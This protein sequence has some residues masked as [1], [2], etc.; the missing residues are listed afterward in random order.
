MQLLKHFKELTVHP[1]NA[2]ELKGLIL[3]LAIQGK[4]T[5][6]W[7][8][9]NP[10]VE[11]ASV[12]LEKILE[13]K[14]QLINDKKI[15]KEKV[16]DDVLPDQ[17][18]DLPNG[19]IKTRL[20]EVIQI[21]RGITFPSSE[22][23]KEDYEG[24][25]PCLRTANV[26]D[27]IDWDDLLYID[28]KYVKRE[29]QILQAGDVIM[30]MAN[31]RE[32]VGKV[33]LLK[34]EMSREFTLG[35]FISALRTYV[36]DPE[37]LMVLLRNP[38]TKNELIASSSQTTNIANV[39]IAKLRPLIIS[40]PPLEEQ[41]AIV[42]TVNQ[43]F[44][45]VEALEKQTQ[46]RV[47]LKEDFVTSALQQLAT[48][49]TVKEWSFLQAHFKTFFTEKTAVKKLR[50]TILQ[51]A[52]QGKLTHHWRLQ[53]S[54]PLEEEVFNSP[55]LEGCPQ[56]GVVHTAPDKSSQDKVVK[57][58]A[59]N[60]FSLPYNPALKERAKALRKAGNLSEVLF[61]NEV[62]RKQF[63]GLDFDRQKIIGNYI[64][65]FY[66]PNCQVV[67]EIDGSSH[68]HK[69]AYDAKR[70]AYLEGLGL[71]VIHIPDNDIKKKLAYTMN[72]LME[73]PALVVGEADAVVSPHAAE[74]V[75]TAEP[76]RAGESV[77]TAEPP[78]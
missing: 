53:N 62:K 54:P 51:L 22:K 17:I 65:D 8:E 28:R 5:R 10:D 63:K 55:P 58:N 24:K 60:Y 16:L 57:R 77:C 25:I 23:S 4:L 37:Y 11:P 49:D 6:K 43:L 20:G 40:F 69:Q 15:K 75:R 45:E 30:S 14:V 50:E 56:G 31:S 38:K 36:F 39:S 44:E 2:Q 64:V 35:G 52:V 42:A 18:S 12:L 9:Q 76:P 7:R 73:H 26:Q 13:E 21:V 59:K 70:D 74:T 32:L 72:A 78:R 29:D 61:W 47:Q 41:K 34:K 3:Q 71:T 67:I 48:G 68:D 33:A 1:K 66:C 46:A 19:W 27:E